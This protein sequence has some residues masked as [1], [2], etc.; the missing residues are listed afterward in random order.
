MAEKQAGKKL[1]EEQ[2]NKGMRIAKYIAHSGYCSRRAAE[3]L[4]EEGAVKVNG[5]T[6]DNPATLITDQ[7][8]KINNKLIA[9]EKEVRVWIIHKPQGVITTS[10]DDK[11]RQTIFDLL[12]KEM[13]R[14]IS[15]GRL[16][17]NTEGLLIL[18]TNGDFARHLELPKNKF[19]RKYRVRVF[20]KIDEKRL[21]KL[22][23]GIRI[24][25]VQ[26]G[27]ID[28]EIDNKSEGMNS[29]LT[30]SI[31]E[32]KNRE[33]RKVMEYFGLQVNRLI[34]T[35]FGPFSLGTIKTKQIQEIPRKVLQKNFGQD[36]RF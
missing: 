31:E 15:V 33:I 20:G 32:G 21:K 27:K 17:F 25:G 29:W 22:T 16:D 10:K 14:T 28:V 23:N 18:T 8:V 3:D 4:I 35:N 26:Y 36:F 34:R 9:L 19:V 11:G 24:E 1:S 6:I 5:Q 7:A 30:V 2:E 12:P 13:P